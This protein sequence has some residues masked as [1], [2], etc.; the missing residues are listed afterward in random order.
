[1]ACLHK[2]MSGFPWK[3]NCRNPMNEELGGVA[4]MLLGQL[5]DALP[6]AVI[7]GRVDLNILGIE[8]DSRRVKPGDLFVATRWG[9]SDGHDRVREAIKGGA[10]A[11]VLERE[12]P[13]EGQEI[14]TIF[15]PNSREALARLASRFYGDPG[16]DLLIIG[17]TGTKGKTTT[18]HLIKSVFDHAGLP[19]GLIGTAGCHIGGQIREV[20]R[21]AFTTPMPADLHRFLAEMVKAG[22]K[23]VALEATSQALALERLH[24][25][26]FAGAVF[27][28]LGRDHIEFHGSEEAY[29]AAKASL[30]ESLPCDERPRAIINVDDPWGRRLLQR[31]TAK[32]MTYGSHADATVR[33]AAAEIRR[34]GSRIRVHT[35]QGEV[36][37]EL[38]LL[39]ALHCLNA[40]AALAVGLAWG[41]PVEGIRRGLESVHAVPG[42]FEPI[43]TGQ[44]FSVIVDSAYSPDS[45]AQ[46]LR[47]ARPLS[48]NRL[49]LVFGCEGE[50]RSEQRPL[51]GAIA[52]QFADLCILTADNPRHDNPEA[53]ARDIVA[54]MGVTTPHHIIR[55]RREAIGFAV[56]Q[57]REGE[58]VL[59]TGK[60]D[61]TVQLIGD[62]T[63]YFND[64][65]IAIEALRNRYPP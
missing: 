4:Q 57:A 49:I 28:N 32:A 19:A 50:R 21:P 10:T 23:A 14:T 6:G 39:G 40:V 31:S 61:E 16:Q 54:G 18:C 43:R 29:F 36:A 27:T 2:V 9:V 25:L 3:G 47:A 64:G 44:P 7:S 11:L 41:L 58:V 30:F 46:V 55:D 53:I 33:V 37:L 22:Q 13:L 52:A 59:I 34:D 65:E 15:V 5:L 38:S 42:R 60:G 26:P 45:L 48:E 51:M 63:S 8:S 1:M 56:E 12:V 20:P 24:G 35:P 62:E 17:V